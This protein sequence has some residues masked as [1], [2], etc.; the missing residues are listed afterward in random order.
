MVKCSA[1]VS[2]HPYQNDKF[3]CLQVSLWWIWKLVVSK[4]LHETLKIAKA[5]IETKSWRV[6]F[7]LWWHIIRCILVRWLSVVTFHLF[8]IIVCYQPCQQIMRPCVLFTAMLITHFG[9]INIFWINVDDFP[10]ILDS[11]LAIE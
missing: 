2:Q 6:K 1:N 3:S 8:R 7:S 9:S 10:K 5:I 4:R 11:L